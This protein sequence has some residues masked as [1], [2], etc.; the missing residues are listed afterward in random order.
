MTLPQSIEKNAEE[1][2]KEIQAQQAATSFLIED[3][4]NFELEFI[5]R[6]PNYLPHELRNAVEET[7]KIKIGNNANVY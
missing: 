4:R 1:T 7:F 3:I 6:H 5:R 2:L